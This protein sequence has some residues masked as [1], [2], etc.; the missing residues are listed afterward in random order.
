MLRK[1]VAQRT[2]E[3]CGA[4]NVPTLPYGRCI[5]KMRYPDGM[6]RKHVAQRYVPTQSNV[7]KFLINGISSVRLR[8]LLYPKPILDKITGDLI[9]ST[10][11]H[12]T[13]I[14]THEAIAC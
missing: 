13:I 6:L 8:L 3:L 4:Q 12:I 11:N 14:H 5:T 10:K 1:H 9:L 2:S 7:E